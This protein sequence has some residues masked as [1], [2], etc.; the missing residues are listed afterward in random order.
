MNYD[1]T[2]A[3][4]SDGAGPLRGK[5]KAAL[6]K[7]LSAHGAQLLSC[8]T[9]Q[10]T[11]CARVASLFEFTV[12]MESEQLM[13]FL[14][15]NPPDK[16]QPAVGTDTQGCDAESSASLPPIALREKIA[17]VKREFKDVSSYAGCTPAEYV[18]T[19]LVGVQ[20][21]AG[22][23]DRLSAAI[24]GATSDERAVARDQSREA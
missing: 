4:L 13:Q 8:E 6:L 18:A 19:Q 2:A 23:L 7:Y 11:H 1:E 10:V 16:K 14:E 21:L 24:T 22:A 5:K 12:S 20:L 15:Q 9:A 3:L 17:E